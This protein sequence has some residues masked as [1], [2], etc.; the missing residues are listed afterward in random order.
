MQK[1]FKK[2][3]F[4][5]TINSRIKNLN[6]S[7]I[8]KFRNLKFNYNYNNIILNKLNGLKVTIKTT[9]FIL[10]FRAK[11]L[12][13]QNLVHCKNIGAYTDLFNRLLNFLSST[14]TKKGFI[15]HSIGYYKSDYL[16]YNSSFTLY[17][18]GL[19]SIEKIRP[20]CT[21]R[22]DGCHWNLLCVLGVLFLI[23]G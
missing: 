4:H 6:S 3:F 5:I 11:I 10:I 1:P 21:L 16:Y 17:F 14:Y 7:N 18:R 12:R 9:P 20:L 15:S 2:Y 23:G 22:A 19:F 13:K 8:I